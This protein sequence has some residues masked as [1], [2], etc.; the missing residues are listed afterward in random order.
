MGVFKDIYKY[1][2]FVWP[3]RWKSWKDKMT[4]YHIW[5]F[6]QIC[7]KFHGMVPEIEMKKEGRVQSLKLL[8]TLLHESAHSYV[9]KPHYGVSM[10]FN[11]YLTNL[12]VDTVPQ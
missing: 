1:A 12:M 7:V 10:S 6:L 9:L 8:S 3:L 4:A 5:T 2:T 11:V